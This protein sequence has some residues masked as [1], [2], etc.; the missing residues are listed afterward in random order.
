MIELAIE[1]VALDSSE[2]PEKYEKAGNW[3]ENEE[4]LPGSV[5]IRVNQ[6]FYVYYDYNC[7]EYEIPV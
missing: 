6:N 5:L 7:C 4:N 2:T 3:T 1:G